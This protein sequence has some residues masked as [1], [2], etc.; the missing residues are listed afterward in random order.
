MPGAR[1][2]PPTVKTHKIRGMIQ[3]RRSLAALA[4]CAALLPASKTRAQAA[5]DSADARLKALYT[6]EWNWRQREFGRGEGGR[7][8]AVDAA[9]QAKRLDYWTRALNTLSA[10]PFDQLSLEEK[11]NAQVF[12]ASI[13]GLVIDVKYKVYE[14]PFN[15][16]T[17]FWTS[18]TPRFVWAPGWP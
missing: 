8:A 3:I 9:S 5:G 13:E 2:L 12:K 1:N 6:E 16:D 10:I 15:A 4:L 18:F 11:V 14:T 17:F 7:F